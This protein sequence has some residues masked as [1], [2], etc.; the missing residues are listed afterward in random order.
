MNI[1]PYRAGSKS[2]K[3]LC[4][5]LGIKSIRLKGSKFKGR[6]GKLVLN[7]GASDMPQQYMAGGVVNKPEAVGLASNKLDLFNILLGDGK[8]T[9]PKFTVSREEAAGWIRDGGTVV[10]RTLLR[11]S[12]GRGIVIAQNEEELVAA[13]LYVRY[14]SK[15]DEYRVHIFRGKVFDVQQKARSLEVPDEKVNWQVRNHGNGFIYKREGIDP[16]KDVLDQALNAFAASGLDFGAVDV[17]F[18]AKHR[19]AYVLEI[20]TAPG[21]E[22]TTLDK[23]TKVFQEN[24]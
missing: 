22:G 20:N 24:L 15:K 6:V 13:P 8:S 19:K 17:I 9:I 23:Y 7:W 18:N 1:Y 4:Q 16:P 21:L 2:V 5:R 11:G 12:E 10:C 14:V 3:A